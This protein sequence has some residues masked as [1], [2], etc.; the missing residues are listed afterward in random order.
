MASNETGAA[1]D[2]YAFYHHFLHSRQRNSGVE[3]RDLE[4]RW[5]NEPDSSSKVP[6]STHKAV[7]DGTKQGT[8]RRT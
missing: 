2:Q 8:R 6:G 1:G 3:A 7:R 4:A 5:I